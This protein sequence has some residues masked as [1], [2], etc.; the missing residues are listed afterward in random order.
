QQAADQRTAPVAGLHAQAAA[1]RYPQQRQQAGQAET[2]GADD[3]GRQFAQQEVIGQ[4]SGAPADVDDQRGAEQQERAVTRGRH[5]AT[6]S[7]RRRAQCAAPPV[8]PAGSLRVSSTASMLMA[9]AMPTKW[10][11]SL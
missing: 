7:R 11:A 1:R 3:E 2:Q 9:R 5:G 10:K 6:R 8:A 4:A